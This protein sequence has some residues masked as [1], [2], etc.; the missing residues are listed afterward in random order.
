M[1]CILFIGHFTK[2]MMNENPYY[3]TKKIGDVLT[4][5]IISNNLKQKYPNSKIDFLCH[6]NCAAVLKENPNIDSIIEFPINERESHRSLLEYMFKIRQQKYDAV[7]DVYSK[8][9]TNLIT[10]FSGAKLKISYHK[11]YSTLFY[12]HN[13]M[14]FNGKKTTEY[15]LQLTIDYCC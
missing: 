12:N 9:G 13:L 4:S 10:L 15:G 14:R 2:K 3:P 8:L 11:W 5:T 6:S 1:R 7:I